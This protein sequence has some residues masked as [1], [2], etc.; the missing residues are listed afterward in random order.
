MNTVLS[1]REIQHEL[2]TELFSRLSV[3][4][5]EQV[6][7]LLKEQR[8]IIKG[9][10]DSLVKHHRIVAAIQAHRNSFVPTINSIL[11]SEILAEIFLQL[12]HVYKLQFDKYYWMKITHV[13]R[14][15]RDVA[16]SF[17]RLFSDIH[18]PTRDH[19]KFEELIRLSDTTP[20]TLH[21]D[22]YYS[23]DEDGSRSW[24]AIAP[25]L[26]RTR[27]L[28]MRI[29]PPLGTSWPYCPQMA[30][31]AWKVPPDAD[32]FRS[33]DAVHSAL[34]CM[35]NLRSLTSNIYIL[36]AVWFK[37][38]FAST[39]TSL[40]IC[41]NR[42]SSPSLEELGAA[43]SVLTSL[44]TLILEG[45][46]KGC[47]K[48]STSSH[49]SCPQL[50]HLQLLRLHGI[51]TEVA[52]IL[53][54]PFRSAAIGMKL[55]ADGYYTDGV[56]LMSIYSRLTTILQ[57]GPQGMLNREI[58]VCRINIRCSDFQRTVQIK[59]WE[60]DQVAYPEPPVLDFFFD[61]PSR[62]P[63]TSLSFFELYDRLIVGLWPLVSN[64]RVLHIDGGVSV[65]DNHLLAAQIEHEIIQC[66]GSAKLLGSMYDTVSLPH[67][68]ELRI[69]FIGPVAAFGDP[70]LKALVGPLSSR[71]ERGYKLENLIIVDNCYPSTPNDHHQFAQDL[72]QN[73][74]AI[75]GRVE[76]RY[77]V[78][79]WYCY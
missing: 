18:F 44:T 20:L 54:L 45:V 46:R 23:D 9:L 37:M 3:S 41:H 67:I 61:Y 7:C 63:Q 66:L 75:V 25:H 55:N 43:L 60:G 16:L 31:L 24:E 1:I 22:D 79:G 71:L 49:V 70:S 21:V 12:V 15:W 58:R 32:P 73:L 35:P 11:P 27:S 14:Y 64:T 36:G 2:D 68:Q 28:L 29:I 30:S 53:K 74:S 51:D 10:Q 39:L 52:N 38:P 4:G 34:V 62:N 56:A 76:V 13:C 65:T 42:C 48:L 59:I 57:G 77:E 72:V 26:S 69:S 19:H 17:P 33:K 50:P 78:G 8:G 6:D 47:Y 40:E 5:T